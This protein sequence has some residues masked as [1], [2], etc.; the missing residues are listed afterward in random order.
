MDYSTGEGGKEKRVRIEIRNSDSEVNYAEKRQ[1]Q[2]NKTHLKTPGSET[3]KSSV[4]W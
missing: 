1:K 4:F 3:T 2:T